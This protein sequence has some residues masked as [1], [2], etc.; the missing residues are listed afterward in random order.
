MKIDIETSDM[1]LLDDL[2]KEN[3]PNLEFVQLMRACQS[4]DWIPPVE[5]VLYFIVETSKDLTLGLFS[6]WLYD[7]FK[8]KKTDTISINGTNIT[9]DPEKITVIINNCIQVGRNNENEE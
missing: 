3:I 2:E 9:N 1:S 8:D 6:A 7:R 5:K 4:A